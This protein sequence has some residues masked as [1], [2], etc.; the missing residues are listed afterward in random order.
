MP[1]R[2]RTSFEKVTWKRRVLA[3]LLALVVGVTLL[4]PI[5]DLT[6]SFSVNLDLLRGSFSRGWTLFYVAPPFA[7]IVFFF[8]GLPALALNSIALRR[9]WSLFAYVA[10]GA[11][12]GILGFIILS[13][14]ILLLEDS[15][16]PPWDS[17]E[18]SHWRLYL[19]VAPPLGVTGAICSVVAWCVMAFGQR[20][21]AQHD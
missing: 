11:V 2:L 4:P 21:S 1:R 19:L 3:I 13:E 6:R 15:S 17:P 20:Q 8:W 16:A 18:E 7:F 12:V 5:W 10:G 9:N 14:T